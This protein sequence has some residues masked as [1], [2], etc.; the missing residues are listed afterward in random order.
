MKPRAELAIRDAATVILTREHDE[1]WQVLLVKRSA[2]SA[3]M[4]DLHVYPGGAL[5]PQDVSFEGADDAARGICQG[6]TQQDA[7]ARLAE[8]HI[9]PAQAL[10]LYFAAIREVFEEAGLL[11][12]RRQDGQE[13]DANGPGGEAFAAYRESLMSGALSLRALLERERLFIE[14]E[15]L[16]YFARWITPD[17][18]TRRFDARFFI[19]R[20]PRAQRAIV[21]LGEV[22]SHIWDTPGAFLA[23]YARGEI[24]LSPPT[25]S[26]LLRL[27]EFEDLEALERHAALCR[28]APMLPDVRPEAPQPLFLL[29]HHPDYSRTLL[30]EE[31]APRW[32]QDLCRDTPAWKG[33]MRSKEG[34]WNT[35]P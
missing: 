29:P 20:A 16:G 4:P 13:F 32:R 11:L 1:G 9:T 10:G 18:G 23:R 34:T 19:V 22:V 31:L 3:F 33:I 28:P 2:K 5:D 8:P 24:E 25:Y 35:L 14:P 7:F 21:D 12:A 27:A 26:T 30:Q 17:G 15:K 6:F